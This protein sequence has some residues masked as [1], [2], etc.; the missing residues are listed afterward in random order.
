[1]STSLRSI[2]GNEIKVVAQPRQID[3]QYTGF[4]GAHGV[5]GMHLGSRGYQLV[6]SGT[7]RATGASYAA[8]SANLQIIIDA[9]ELYLFA[10]AADYSHDGTTYYSVV[11]DRFQLLPDGEGKSFHLTSTDYVTCSFIYY[12]RALK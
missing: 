4:P 1:M 2:F 12:A 8:A 10:I 7:L 5:I 6:I 3:R 11:L 9:L